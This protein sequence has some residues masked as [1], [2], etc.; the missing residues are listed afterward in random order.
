M[1]NYILIVFLFMLMGIV[2]CA[3]SNPESSKFSIVPN[4]EWSKPHLSIISGNRSWEKEALKG[5]S[6]LVYPMDWLM[7]V[8]GSGKKDEADRWW[9]DFRSLGKAVGYMDG[10]WE[11]APGIISPQ[12]FTT[13]KVSFTRYTMVWGDGEVY[14][15]YEIGN[16]DWC[17]SMGD[18]PS[19]MLARCYPYRYLIQIRTGRKDSKGR[20]IPENNT[21]TCGH[22]TWHFPGLGGAFHK[23]IVLMPKDMKPEDYWVE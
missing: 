3:T 11:G 21:D 16:W 20:W 15:V 22:E 14:P 2:G 9:P 18:W 5:E 8:E 7:M 4:N 10:M 17:R 1:K 23:G 19:Y 12:T 13:G 6:Y